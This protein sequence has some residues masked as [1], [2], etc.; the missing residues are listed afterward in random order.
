MPW[1]GRCA[2][3]RAGRQPVGRHG[4]RLGRSL[5][6]YDRRGLPAVRDHPWH[7][8]GCC[9]TPPRNSF[10][11]A[12]RRPTLSAADLPLSTSGGGHQ[13]RRSAIGRPCSF[14][15]GPRSGLRLA[16]LGPG[17]LAG[18]TI[19]DRRDRCS[20]VS[21]LPTGAFTTSAR[22]SRSRVTGLLPDLRAP[23]DPRAGL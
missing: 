22:C 7:R 21:T 16:G 1:P 6:R 19:L 5:R 17:I 14:R 11:K 4:R 13:P 20:K 15:P 2:V 12:H 3:A 10:V 18:S 8:A 9:S 23:S